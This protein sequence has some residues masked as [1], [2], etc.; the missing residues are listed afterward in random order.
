M[1]QHCFRKC[2]YGLLTTAL[3]LSLSSISLQAQATYTAQLRGTV[4]DATGAVVPK[5]TV[6]VTNP[7]TQ[8]S[9]VATTDDVGRYIFPA[10]KPSSYSVK[11]EAV[12]FK[13]I[14]R[15]NIEL[16]VSQQSDL[17]FTLALGEITE[18]VQVTSESTLLNTVSAT[19]GTEV[20]NRYI[21]DMPLLDRALSNLTFLAPGVTEV[22]D[23]GV[24]S[25]RGTN[26]VSNGQRNGTAEI[27]L[28][29]G[30][31]TVS[32]SGEGGNT[33]VNYQPSLEIIQEF[34]VSNNSFSAEYGNNGGTVINIVTKSGTN[35]FHGS[36]WWFARR[37][38]FDANDF[39]S[40][41]DGQGKGDY[42][43]DEWGGSIGGPIRKQ[44]S[45]FFFDFLKTRNNSP[46]TL[47]T[48]VPTEAQRR[49]DF[50]QTF[51][52]DGTLQQI[53]NP[54]DVQ[55]DADGNYIRQPFA[56]NMIP[57]DRIDP[58]ALNIMKLYPEATGA[59]DDITGR[60]Y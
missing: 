40:N 48:T 56:N 2:W 51:N 23:A 53:F 18:T 31:S 11:V 54:F 29:G 4:K 46:F 58:V 36:G 1:K 30:L 22:P 55:Q 41:R 45:F 28:D 52:D 37:P 5:A 26:F 9:E 6:T 47:T 17:D 7:A 21:V 27:R 43:K 35:D 38:R 16:R 14:L 34:K 25:I 59:G 15:S 33:I 13:T 50:S 60:N 10:L 57:L 39:Y 44:K 3:M 19:L 42:K 49:G 20:T 24:D 32:E 8:V 12:G